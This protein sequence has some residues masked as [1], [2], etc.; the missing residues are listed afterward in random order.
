MLLFDLVEDK[1]DV[2]PLESYTHTH[3]CGLEARVCV[4][5][6]INTLLSSPS[7]SKYDMGNKRGCTGVRHRS[8]G[9]SIRWTPSRKKV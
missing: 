5:S 8:F 2:Y 1:G 3:R 4:I 9:D 7:R 6:T